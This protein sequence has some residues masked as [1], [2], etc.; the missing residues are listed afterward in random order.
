M[1]YILL[2]AKLIKISLSIYS[3]IYDVPSR[4]GDKFGLLVQC[5]NRGT[6]SALVKKGQYKSLML[7]FLEYCYKRDCMRLRMGSVTNL[8]DSKVLSEVKRN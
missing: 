1:Y 5:C 6:S 7:L 3:F 8:K 2:N 4:L